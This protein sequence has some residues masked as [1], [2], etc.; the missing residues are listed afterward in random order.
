MKDA[1]NC[2]VQSGLSYT[3]QEE[4]LKADPEKQ[5]LQHSC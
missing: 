5:Q 2:Y 1:Y 3:F 4:V